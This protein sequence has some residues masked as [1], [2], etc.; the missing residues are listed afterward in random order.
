[1]MNS[2]NLGKTKRRSKWTVNTLDDLHVV[3]GFF[4]S[5]SWRAL[6]VERD[7]TWSQNISF[8]LEE[9]WWTAPFIWLNILFTEQCSAIV[10][11]RVTVR[12][13]ARTR[14]YRS[15]LNRLAVE[16]QQNEIKNCLCDKHEPSAWFEVN[17]LWCCSS[18][19]WCG[20]LIA[21]P[22]QKIANNQTPTY[23]TNFRSLAAN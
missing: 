16:V 10:T 11:H 21:H 12:L 23:Q 8:L 9:E 15:P 14:R 3:N 5:G 20:K 2:E 6:F 18:H 7:S 13:S 4:L 17:S 19:Y 1:M 22:C